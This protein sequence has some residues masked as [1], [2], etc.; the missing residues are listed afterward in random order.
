MGRL[1]DDIMAVFGIKPSDR[2][3]EAQ[4]IHSQQKISNNHQSSTDVIMLHDLPTAGVDEEL[5]DCLSCKVVGTTT[6]TAT[7]VA[8]AYYTRKNVH[9]FTGYQR[10]AVYGQGASLCTRNRFL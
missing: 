5:L 9:R 8:V 7:A 3:P 6:L 2:V 4:S 10:I 1:M